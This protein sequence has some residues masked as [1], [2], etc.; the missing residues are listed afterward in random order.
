[1]AVGGHA[2]QGFSAVFGMER[3]E[4]VITS[5]GDH[6]GHGKK[7]RKLQSGG[8]GHAGHLSGGNGGHGARCARKYR[9]RHLADADPDGLDERNVFHAFRHVAAHGARRTE[10]SVDD[11]HDD[12]ASMDKPW[13]IGTTR[14]AR[15][16]TSS[17]TTS[18]RLG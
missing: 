16:I 1:M 2:A 14:L 12:A 4:Q 11:P 10:I 3:F 15:S 9:R 17:M 5:G 18:D 8:A 13:G 7:E 6:G